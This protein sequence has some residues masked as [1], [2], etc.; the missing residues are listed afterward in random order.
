MCTG[1]LILVTLT[2][3]A[4]VQGQEYS[5]DDFTLQFGDCSWK[6]KPYKIRVPEIVEEALEETLEGHM[7]IMSGKISTLAGV[8][9]TLGTKQESAKATYQAQDQLQGSQQL[10]ETKKGAGT[11]PGSP[12]GS[13]G[14]H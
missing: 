9:S 1:H 5:Q 13:G 3:G 7:R 11:P 2:L 6:S 10:A 12:G 8:V 4:L 14:A